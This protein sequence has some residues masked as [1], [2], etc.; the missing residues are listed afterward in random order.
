MLE[1]VVEYW[2]AILGWHCIGIVLAT[3]VYARKHEIIKIEDLSVIA[4]M[5][6]LGPL[7]FLIAL[8]EFVGKFY[9]NQKDTVLWKSRRK[10]T[11]DILYSKDDEQENPHN[12]FRT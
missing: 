12:P 10:K 11:Q 4:L 1:F 6:V 3:F 7:W 8:L 5:G 9:V 2:D